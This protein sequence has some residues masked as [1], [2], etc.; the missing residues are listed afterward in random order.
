MTVAIILIGVIGFGV[1]MYTS[2]MINRKRQK[3]AE[4]ERYE[5]IAREIE[6]ANKTSNPTETL[7]RNGASN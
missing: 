5:S 2:V 6:A 7:K 4:N 3:Q 1:V